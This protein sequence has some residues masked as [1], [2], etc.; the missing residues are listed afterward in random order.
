MGHLVMVNAN[1]PTGANPMEKPDFIARYFLR[2][3]AIAHRASPTRKLSIQYTNALLETILIFV[4]LPM[5]GVASVVLIPSI[6]WAPNTIAKWFGLSPRVA[7]FVLWILSLVVGYWWLGK[8]LKK[9]RQDRSTY[10]QFASEK[11]TQIAFW[12]KVGVLLACGIVLPILALLVTF[13]TQ[14]FTRAFD[15]H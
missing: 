3:L 13:G 7:L 6:R 4:G 9:Y 2:R 5:L 14:V 12:Q 11:D 8:R 15:L 1:K 10:M